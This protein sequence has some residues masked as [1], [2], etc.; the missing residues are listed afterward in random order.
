VDGHHG[1]LNINQIILAQIRCPLSGIAY[2]KRA[3]GVR[4]RAQETVGRA[5]TASSTLWASAA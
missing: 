4:Q 2:R 1:A 3:K 5:L